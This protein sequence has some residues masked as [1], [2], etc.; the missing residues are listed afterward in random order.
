[1]FN[2]SSLK[3][4]I[5][6]NTRIFFSL[7]L[8]LFVKCTHSHRQVKFMYSLK[9]HCPRRLHNLQSIWHTVWCKHIYQC[10]LLN[11]FTF[12]FINWHQRDLCFYKSC[13]HGFYWIFF[14]TSNP[15]DSSTTDVSNDIINCCTALLPA[16]EPSLVL[17]VP[18]VIWRVCLLWKRC[19]NLSHLGTIKTQQLMLARLSRFRYVFMAIN[20][21]FIVR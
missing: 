16:T 8:T 9:S 2:R 3:V 20:S 13:I 5:T 19:K 17:L 15:F 21:S 6:S 10:P 4:V 18:P 14:F 12:H 11:T 7:S 1:M